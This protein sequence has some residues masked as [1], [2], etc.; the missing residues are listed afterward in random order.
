M[1]NHHHSRQRLQNLLPHLV[2]HKMGLI[3]WVKEQ[4]NEAGCPN[5]FRFNAK[6]GNTTAWVAQRN[7][8]V[9][10]GAAATREMAMTKAI[11]EAIERYCP[12]IY[13]KVELPL[14]SYADAHFSCIHPSHFTLFSPQQYQSPEFI[15]KPFTEKSQVHWTVT[16]NLH[17]GESVYIPAT[18]V[19]MPYIIERQTASEI[20][21]TQSISTGLAC[22]CSYEEAIVSGI[23]EV[24]ERESFS[25]TWQAMLSHPRIKN[26]SLSKKNQDLIKLFEKVGYQIDLVNIT[27]DNGIP[28]IMSVARHAGKEAAPLAIAI[29]TAL[30]PENAIKKSLEELA[31]TERYTV[32]LKKYRPRLPLVEEHKNVDDQESHINFWCSSERAV[33]ADFLTSSKEEV[34]FSDLPNVATGD[35]RKDLHVLIQNIAKTGHNI[36]IAD[37]TTEDIRAMGL[38]VIRAIIPGYHPLFMGYNNRSLGGQ[39]LWKVP[40][41][42][43][44]AGISP[45]TGDNPFP[46]P[47]P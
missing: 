36:L 23:C 16:Q 46:H 6:M 11:G 19:Y 34:N 3:Q 5:F 26:A 39:R 18:F 42:L 24:I 43:G 32:R 15:Y 4:A 31:Q 44:Y 8:V 7:Y 1:F 38:W 30:N 27:S 20:L 25:I 41:K 45:E 17:T 28:T 2:N 35:P 14:T 13:N 10:G 40:Q 21:I 33:Y 29:A 47:F 12:A 9:G 22:H 37:I